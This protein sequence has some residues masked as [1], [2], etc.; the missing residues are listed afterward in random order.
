MWWRKL[1]RNCSPTLNLKRPSSCRDF[2]GGWGDYGEGD[3]FI[4]VRVP[5]QRKVAQVLHE[6]SMEDIAALL[7]DEVH[8]YRSVALIMLVYK[9]QK[10][11]PS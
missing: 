4:G 2:Q 11:P 7:H 6:A 9:Y 8:E 1:N 5:W 3:R 10:R